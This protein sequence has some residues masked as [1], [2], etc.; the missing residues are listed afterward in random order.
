MKK[1]E[2]EIPKICQICHDFIKDEFIDGLLR[3]KGQWAI[4]CISCHRQH[5]VGI[6]IGYG[7]YYKR[8]IIEGRNRED[9]ITIFQKVNG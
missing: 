8:V 3:I 2:S 4:M 6:G 1:W 5:G 9:D 7:Q